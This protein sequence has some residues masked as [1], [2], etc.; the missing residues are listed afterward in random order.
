MSLNSILD[1]WIRAYVKQNEGLVL[2]WY[3]DS[4][5]FPTIGYGHLIT[6]AERSSIPH[7]ITASD[8][9]ALFESDY[10]KA[11]S[12]AESHP[13][14]SESLLDGRK[15]ALVD[16]A[17]NMGGSWYKTF[18]NTTKSILSGDWPTAAS[19][20]LQSTYARQVGIRARRNSYLLRTGVIPKTPSFDPD[21]DQPQSEQ[22]TESPELRQESDEDRKSTR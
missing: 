1:S 8:A 15:A 6:P 20:L 11:V 12:E 3:N 22:S 5:G 13:G 21:S 16:L 14:W 7:T 9:E 18:Y 19:G 4:L 2:Q 10:S 17:F